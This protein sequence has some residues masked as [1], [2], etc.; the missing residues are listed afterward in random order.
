MH[1]WNLI[2]F[3][4]KWFSQKPIW[5]VAMETRLYWSLSFLGGIE[6][7]PLDA[8][9]MKHIRNTLKLYIETS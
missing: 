8:W 4:F 2:S 7:V 1:N 3:V 9:I 6:I 5:I